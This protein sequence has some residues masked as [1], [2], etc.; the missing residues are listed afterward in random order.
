MF[1]CSRGPCTS[2]ARTRSSSDADLH[3][4][5]AVDVAQVDLGVVEVLV[6]LV[7]AD[8]GA[9]ACSCS[10]P[11]GP[12]PEC[13]RRC[14]CATRAAR[15]STRPSWPP[16]AAR[17]QFVAERRRPR[18]RRRIS[19]LLPTMLHPDIVD[20]PA[21]V[22]RCRV[23]SI[24][25]KKNSQADALS[26]VRAQVGGLRR[27]RLVRARDLQD[28]RPIGAVRRN[29]HGLAVPRRAR[30]FRL[31]PALELQ[32]RA[33]RADAGR[34]TAR[35]GRRCCARPCCSSIR[36]CKPSYAT[37]LADRSS[38]T[39]HSPAAAQPFVPVST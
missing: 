4:V 16:P 17:V 25:S 36:C 12:P 19:M 37:G 8:V 27:P 32:L 34:S 14:R 28:L 9:D 11:P 21:A 31:V 24:V 5:V 15:R 26:R 33:L 23:P 13:C 35:A 6:L 38:A 7:V 22:L 18:S 30:V 20:V 10:T 2:A 29:G 3:E 39:C 1:V